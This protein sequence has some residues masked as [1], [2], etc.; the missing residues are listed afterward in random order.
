VRD[1]LA[2]MLVIGLVSSSLAQKPAPTASVRP[3]KETALYAPRPDYP[4]SVRKQHKGGAGVFVLHVDS[5]TGVVSSVSIQKSTGVAELDDS[6]VD[7]FRR[8][9]FK[10]HSVPKKVIIPIAF[11]MIN[12]K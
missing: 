9:R 10:P 12:P 4:E 8:W 7:C 6:T 5:D 2:F 1:S 11:K 3:A